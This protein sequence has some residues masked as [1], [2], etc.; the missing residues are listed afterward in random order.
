MPVAATLVLGTAELL[1]LA[2]PDILGLDVSVV[3]GPVPM[4]FDYV[5]PPD[6]NAPAPIPAQPDVRHVP[7]KKA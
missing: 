5:P 1:P 7:Q 2:V 6:P 4:P 3:P